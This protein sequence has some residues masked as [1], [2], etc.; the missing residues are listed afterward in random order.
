MRR[1]SPIEV[2]SS[3]AEKPVDGKELSSPDTSFRCSSA[4][5]VRQDPQKAKGIE[6]GT[7]GESSSVAARILSALQTHRSLDRTTIRMLLGRNIPGIRITRAI[8]TLTKA[9]VITVMMSKPVPTGR[10]R[11]IVRLAGKHLE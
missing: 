1:G 3:E 5:T 4:R 2:L 6:R 7:M 9:G 10:P 8:N 11:T